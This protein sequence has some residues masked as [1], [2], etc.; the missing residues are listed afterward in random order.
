MA[1][2]SLRRATEAARRKGTGRQLGVWCARCAPAACL[3]AIESNTSTN[4]FNTVFK[5]RRDVANGTSAS[6]LRT[7]K[8]TL[9]IKLNNRKKLQR[10]SDPSVSVSV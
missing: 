4:L 6:T 10:R 2:P 3:R 5:I 1:M 8:N 7:E 9:S